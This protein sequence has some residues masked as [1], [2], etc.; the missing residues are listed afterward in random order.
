MCG[1]RG[2]AGGRAGGRGGVWSR[3]VLGG[4]E[5]SEGVGGSDSKSEHNQSSVF[6]RLVVC[7]SRNKCV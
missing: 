2:Q 6:I 4:C 5:E 3:V 1:G 7:E